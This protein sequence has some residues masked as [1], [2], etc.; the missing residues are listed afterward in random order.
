[1]FDE[2]YFMVG[3]APLGVGLS[4]EI[5]EQL[6]GVPNRPSPS[7]LVPYCCQ[8]QLPILLKQ[9]PGHLPQTAL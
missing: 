4:Q 2:E 1:M 5:P 6:V 9:F 7:Y 8:C 3:L